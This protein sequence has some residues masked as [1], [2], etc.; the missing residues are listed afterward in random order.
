MATYRL[1]TASDQRPVAQGTAWFLRPDVVVTAFHVVGDL[2]TATWHCEEVPTITYKLVDH[3]NA[4]PLALSPDFAEP[5]ADVALLR[6]ARECPTAVLPLGDSLPAAGAPWT[7]EGYPAFR[8]GAPFTL[9]GRVTEVR[10]TELNTA[11]QLLVD[12]R[13]EQTWEGM[14]GAPVQSDG[15]VI[16]LVTNETARV[17]TIWAAPVTIIQE[18]E[19]ASL[20][21]DCLVTRY[22]TTAELRQLIG[23]LGWHE[24]TIAAQ[25]SV[26][27]TA[28]VIA[29][30]AARDQAHAMP[31]L[32]SLLAACPASADPSATEAY[33][34]LTARLREG[35]SVEEDP[36]PGAPVSLPDLRDL[37]LAAKQ[38]LVTCL[39]D[40]PSLRD[41]AT[42]AVLIQ[43]LPG[44]IA[45][46]IPRH[47]QSNVEVFNLVQTCLRY[48]GGLNALLEAL[49]FFDAG[50]HQLAAV[51][52]LVESLAQG[53]VR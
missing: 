29:R 26:R 34:T 10:A 38:A 18:L 41:P 19:L 23:Q 21:R 48:P 22:S 20:C 9:S 2:A 40:C 51:H 24:L 25:L 7:S 42:R 1:I 32:L 39:L 13:T 12:Q 47:P 5:H 52:T 3:V 49:R 46:A 44:Q 16:G 53:R 37:S 50:T 11:L 45:Q 33:A 17:D 31:R 8:R 4:S 27:N 14:S 15:R 30:Q 28:A 6:S 35:R 36:C 43:T